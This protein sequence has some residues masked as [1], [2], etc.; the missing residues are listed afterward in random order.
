MY[1]VLFILSSVMEHLGC[2][3]VLAIEYSVAMNIG[4]H[5]LFWIMVFSGHMPTGEIAGSYGS[6]IFSFWRNL[7]TVLHFTQFIFPPAVQEVPF[8][9]YLRQHLLFVDFFWWWPFLWFEVIS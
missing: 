2:F 5:M 4:V 7:H 1:H 8:S 3:Y 6:F 9:P